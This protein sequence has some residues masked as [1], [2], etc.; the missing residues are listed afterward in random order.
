MAGELNT[1]D[2]TRMAA[3]LAR[4]GVEADD[5]ADYITLSRW[6]VTKVL[7]THPQPAAEIVTETDGDMER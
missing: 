4:Y 5:M 1:R 2:F 3:A 6:L 7:E